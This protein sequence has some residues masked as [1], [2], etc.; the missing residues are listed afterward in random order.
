[1]VGFVTQGPQPWVRHA[2]TGL[3]AAFLALVTSGTGL[4]TALGFGASIVVTTSLSIGVGLATWR[5]PA[6]K[7]FEATDVSR[8][9]AHARASIERWSRELEAGGWRLAADAVSLW[10]VLGSKRESYARFYVKDGEPHVVELH[11]LSSPRVRARQVQTRLSDGRWAQTVDQLPDAVFFDDPQLRWQVLPSRAPIEKLL[12][13]HRRLTEPGR[14]APAAGAGTPAAVAAAADARP[15][16]Q[17]DPVE[18]HR[19][20]WREWVGRMTASGQLRQVGD[21]VRVSVTRLALLPL[22]LARNWVTGGQRLSPP[23]LVLLV[24]GALLWLGLL[25]LLEGSG[26]RD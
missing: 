15:V 19:R 7:T 2:T 11:A 26:P 20:S 16:A 23:K 18:L 5:Q 21:E 6:D 9:P 17:D 14:A 25:L 1:V 24:G 22:L 13:A 8:F 12:A 3:L 10:Q 4:F